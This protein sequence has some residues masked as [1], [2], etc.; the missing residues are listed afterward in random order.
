MNKLKPPPRGPA[1]EHGYRHLPELN[2]IDDKARS[3]QINARL[4]LLPAN[5]IDE[6]QALEP[7]FDRAGSMEM[8]G[9]KVYA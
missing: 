4:N 9:E 3:L 6:T 2:Q 5:H 1:P 7:A 8:Q